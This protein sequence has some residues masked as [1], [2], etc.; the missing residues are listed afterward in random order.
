MGGRAFRG[1]LCIAVEITPQSGAS[2]YE[3][4]VPETAFMSE[5][6]LRPPKDVHLKVAATKPREKP[7]L[8]IRKLKLENR[9]TREPA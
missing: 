7:K 4:E 3:R 1:V 5:L 6:K 2:R 8:E 9:E